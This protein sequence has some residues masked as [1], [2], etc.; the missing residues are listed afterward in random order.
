MERRSSIKRTTKET[1][2]SVS[3]VLDCRDESVINSGVPFF[4]HMLASLSKHGRFFINLEC[5]GDTIVDDHHSVEDT[6]ICLG[7]AIKKALGDG[8]GIM[9]FGDSVVPMDDALTLAALDISGRPFF[10]YT[11]LPLEGYI[12]EYNE[13]LTPEFLRALANNA[14]INLHVNVF[15]GDNR[16]HIH[17][18]IFKAL[19]VALFKAFSIDETLGGEIPSTKGIIV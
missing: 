16:H 7:K 18:S 11:G 6:G 8:A 14:G 10:K 13:D 15:Y 2:I 19:G 4:D 17:E 9:R 3:L 1:D 5:K 12:S